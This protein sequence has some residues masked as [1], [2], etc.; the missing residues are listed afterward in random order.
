MIMAFLRFVCSAA[1][2]ATFFVGGVSSQT[3]GTQHDPNNPPPKWVTENDRKREEFNRRVNPRPEGED[4]G[5]LLARRRG[6]GPSLTAERKRIQAL[7]APYPGDLVKYSAFLRQPRTG[8]F[9][10]F[11]DADCEKGLLV[12][13]GGDCANHIPGASTYSF[14]EGSFL[15]D[16]HFNNGWLNAEGFFS[17]QILVQLGDFPIENVSLSTPGVD[18]LDAF[19]PAT[20]FSG[21][22]AQNSEIVSGIS[23]GDLLFSTKSKPVLDNTYAVRVVAYRNGNNL[24]KRIG[25]DFSR[26]DNIVRKFYNVQYDNRKDVIVAFRVIRQETDGNITVLWKELKRRKSPV[27]VFDDEEKLRDF[28]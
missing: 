26:K 6:R 2:V 24:R 22:Q 5:S 3:G 20:A 7:Q 21:A 27:I 23:R 12:N 8:M 4:L 10:L 9:R 25:W 16:V 17:Q 28:K 13:V 18:F 14:R 11:P 1:F 15:S 19:V